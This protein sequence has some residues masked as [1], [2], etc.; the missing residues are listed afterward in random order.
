MI[1]TTDDTMQ[2]NAEFLAGAVIGHKIASVSVEVNPNAKYY[3]ERGPYTVITLD[4]GTRVKLEDT[5]DCCAYT[6]LQGFF[7]NPQ[8]VDH[9]ITGVRTENDFHHWFI[10]AETAD[11]ARMDVAWS[12]GNPYYYSYGFG[13]AVSKIED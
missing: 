1:E 6:E 8:N 2:S 7:L 10:M 13:I 3:W 4:N 12:E 9:V 5:S 11:I